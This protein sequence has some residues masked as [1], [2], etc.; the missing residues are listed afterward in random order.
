[1][2]N[3]YTLEQVARSIQSDRRAEALREQKS[4]IAR[5]LARQLSK[6]S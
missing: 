4:R 1:M 3:H 6:R 5:R 2:D